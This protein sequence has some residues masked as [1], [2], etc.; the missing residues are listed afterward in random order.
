[1]MPEHGR[2]D[3]HKLS[4]GKV[5]PFTETCPDTASRPEGLPPITQRSRQPGTPTTSHQQ[6]C[7]WRVPFRKHRER[8]GGTFKEKGEGAHGRKTPVVCLYWTL[9]LTTL[10]PTPPYP[11]SWS[12]LHMDTSLSTPHPHPSFDLDA[13]VDLYSH[14]LSLQTPQPPPPPYPLLKEITI[15]SK[16]KDFLRDEKDSI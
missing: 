5:H 15:V 2:V 8:G 12:G 4:Q 9:V 13:R 16:W 1:M 14:P 6:W 3:R 7:N 11:P 10:L